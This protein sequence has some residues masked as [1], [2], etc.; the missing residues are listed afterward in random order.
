M[1]DNKDYVTKS[2]DCIRP[3]ITVLKFFVHSFIIWHRNMSLIL[4]K[5]L[6]M[7]LIEIFTNR[8]MRAAYNLSSNILGWWRCIQ[9]L[10][11]RQLWIFENRQTL[12]ELF[13]QLPK[14]KKINSTFN[15]EKHWPKKFIQKINFYSK[16]YWTIFLTICV[17]IY[18]Y[19]ATKLGKQRINIFKEF[20]ES[21]DQN[22]KK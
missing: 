8:S 18:V 11:V 3:L 6:I 13:E 19:K 4:R 21:K 2:S 20:F 7:H 5:W 12:F 22:F 17:Q 9:K 1:F 14:S 16:S 10:F 15:K